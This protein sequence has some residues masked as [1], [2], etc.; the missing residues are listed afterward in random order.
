[1]KKVL[2]KL[3]SLLTNKQGKLYSHLKAIKLKKLWK[4]YGTGHGVNIAVLDLFGEHGDNV[5]E[6]IRRI[7]PHSTIHF[8]NWVEN[9][10]SK[11]PEKLQVIYNS[12]NALK[13]DI[14]N[15]SLLTGH[16]PELESIIN[17]LHNKGVLL[18]ASSG[19][20]PRY[21]YYPAKYLDEI[22]SVGS[23]YHK[24]GKISPFTSKPYEVLAPGEVIYG[25]DGVGTSYAAPHVSGMIACMLSRVKPENIEQEV[26]KWLD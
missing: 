2:Q 25:I 10:I 22:I 3:L 19:N 24:T 18:V 15:M 6:I 20:D 8:Y 21:E 17:K 16:T 11:I 5:T 14:I 23:L 7:A 9:G 1:M 4:E 26:I 12:L 13:I